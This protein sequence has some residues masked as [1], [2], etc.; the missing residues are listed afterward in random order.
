MRKIKKITAVNMAAVLL[1]MSLTACGS[2]DVED[3]PDRED[4]AEITADIAEDAASDTADDVTPAAETP[5]ETIPVS[6]MPDE[7]ILNPETYEDYVKAANTYLQTDDVIQA[8]AVLDEGIEKLSAG[9]QGAETQEIDL[10]SQRK[11][12]ILAGTVAVET[13]CITNRYDDD[14]SMYRS[15]VSEHDENG[16]MLSYRSVNYDSAGETSSA[17]EYQYDGNGNRIRYNYITYDND[18]NSSIS[19]YETWAYDEKGNQIEHVRC[20]EDRNIKERT[21][22]EYDA[23]GNQIR[24]EKF[25]EDGESTYKLLKT[26]NEHG[27]LLLFAEY[28]DGSLENKIEREFDE[29][30]KERKAV[31]YDGDGNITRVSESEYAEND[32][33]L[34]HIDYNAAG[35]IDSEIVYGYDENGNLI[36]RV[37]YNYND[38]GSIDRIWEENYDETGNDIYGSYE[39]SGIVTA[40]T[41][42][43]CDEDG[44][45]IRKTQTNYDEDT[46][47]KTGEKVTEYTYDEKKNRIKYDYARYEGKEKTNSFIWEK[48]YDEDGRETSFSFYDNQKSASY[49]SKT[50][51]DENGLMINYT[52]YDENGDV[53]SRRETEYDESGNVIRENDYDAD[54]SLILYY[55]NEYDDFG[56]ITRQARYEDGILKTEK[57]TSYAYHYIGNIY[58]EAADYID[59]NLQ[60]RKIFTRFLN[61]QEKV[62][63]YRNEGVNIEGKIVEMTIT[64]FL[65]HGCTEGVLTY[66]FLDMTGDGI[67]ELIIRCGSSIRI[68]VI[69]CSYG[70]L[71]VIQ[72][73]S[74]DLGERYGEVYLVKRNGKTGI[75]R[76]C[77]AVGNGAGWDEYYFWDKKGNSEIFIEESEYFDKSINEFTNSYS[78]TSIGCFDGRAITKGEYYDIKGGMM[79]EMDIDWQKLE[80]PNYGND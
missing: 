32:R 27:N 25:D 2:G 79:T 6:E 80:E 77:G 3:M 13:N 51:Y 19:H 49:Q 59:D 43:E 66:A 14:G 1:T 60:Q 78:M 48:E 36:K 54:G 30:Y 8:L 28:W 5:E 74:R 22:S 41:E 47:E 34:K 17:I 56:S 40:A 58:A 24:Y 39:V 71:K 61:G 44:N 50:E 72:D 42:T 9:A 53:I 73:V 21:E 31:F 35:V 70:T 55:E 11:E 57:R 18:G 69:Q 64:D 12:Y 46:G 16:N 76:D 75:Y 7:I 33:S 26:Y 15:D 4:V 62:R 20:D 68:A 38:D 67:E 37:Q 10:L 65:N 52:G 45:I 29:N 63:F 23:F